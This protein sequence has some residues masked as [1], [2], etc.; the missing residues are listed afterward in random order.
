MW[1]GEIKVQTVVGGEADIDT[2]KTSM[3]SGSALYLVECFVTT[4]MM[5]SLSLTGLERD[6]SGGPKSDRTP[7]FEIGAGCRN[8]IGHVM[9]LQSLQRV[10]YSVRPLHRVVLLVV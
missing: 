7:L 6:G 5:S 9:F 8:G 2:E 1:D 4:T 10:G 3:K